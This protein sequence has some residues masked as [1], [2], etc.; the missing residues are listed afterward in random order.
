ML[1]LNIH[2]YITILEPH[3]QTRNGLCKPGFMIYAK[4]TANRY[5]YMS[6]S[7]DTINTVKTT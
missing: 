1:I 7:I 5:I 4:Y 2:N 3:F 6:I